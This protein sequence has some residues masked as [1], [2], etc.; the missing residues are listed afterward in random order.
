[1]GYDPGVSFHSTFHP[2]ASIKTVICSNK[3]KGAFDIM[4]KIEDEIQNNFE[5]MKY[6]SW[7]KGAL[8]D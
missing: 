6:C 3:S 5:F 1:M 7:S 4:G 8:I 2:K